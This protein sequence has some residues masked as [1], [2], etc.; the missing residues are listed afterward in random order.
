VAFH[1]WDYY[2]RQ[3]EVSSRMSL[4]INKIEVMNGP[5]FDSQEAVANATIDY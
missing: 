2:V 4:V 1:E 5:L 3:G